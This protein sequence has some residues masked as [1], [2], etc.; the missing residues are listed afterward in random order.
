MAAPE[1]VKTVPPQVINE[2][3]AY[4][5]FNLK[6]F[7]TTSDGTPVRFSALLSSEKAL[8]TGMICTEDGILTGIPA[9]G[10]AGNYEI[11][12]TAQ[13]D[14]GT[15]QAIV[16]MTIKPSLLT[17]GSEYFDK[18][19]AQVWEAL[20]QKLP[21]PDLKELYGRDITPLDVY[22]LLERWG[23]LI[24]WDAYNLDPPAEK[25]LLTL[26]GTSPHY[27]IYDRG[28]CLVGA[29]KDLYS[30]ARTVEDGMQTARAMAK[31]V[32]KRSWTVEMAGFDKFTRAAWIEIQHLNDQHGKS[33]EI[34]N[35]SPNPEDIKLYQKQSEARVLK[36]GKEGL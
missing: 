12:V 19:K 17:T 27:N 7:I 10:T 20:E 1:V 9:K 24:I 29:P 18:L 31:E 36:S 30:Y 23:V 21:V 25:V 34:I 13:N 2:G 35:Y 14:E 3:A 4:G 11:N 26:E 8:P 22:Y 33:L 5:P 28:S 15:I 6:D 32:Y 16:Y